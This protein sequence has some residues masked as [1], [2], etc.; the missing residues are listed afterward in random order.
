ML[1]FKP[2]VTVDFSPE[3][4][5]TDQKQTNLSPSALQ[6]HENSSLSMNFYNHRH[7]CATIVQL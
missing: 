6:L 5:V 4:T 7:I 3:S 1:C 2:P